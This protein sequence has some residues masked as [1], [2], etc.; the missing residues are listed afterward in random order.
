MSEFNALKDKI[1]NTLGRELDDMAMDALFYGTGVLKVTE[2]GIKHV[3]LETFIK[4]VE[5]GKVGD[6]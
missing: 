5:D 4:D 1:K 2:D 3:P 6:K